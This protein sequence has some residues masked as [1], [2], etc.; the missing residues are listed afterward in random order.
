ME[1]PPPGNLREIM[2]VYSRYS[3]EIRNTWDTIHGG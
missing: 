2:R 1:T 3:E